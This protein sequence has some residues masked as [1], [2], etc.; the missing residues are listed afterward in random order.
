MILRAKIHRS[1]RPC[2]YTMHRCSMG[3]MFGLRAGHGRVRMWSAARKSRVTLAVWLLAS[4]CIRNMPLND[5]LAFYDG[6][7]KIITE[8]PPIPFNDTIFRKAFVRTS[9]HPE[10]A[11]ITTSDVTRLIRTFAQSALVNLR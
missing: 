10:T 3:L 5:L 9:L 4:S 7:A 1:V 8:P 6:P 2:V 11:V